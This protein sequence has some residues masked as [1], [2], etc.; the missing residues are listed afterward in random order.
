M[1]KGLAGFWMFSTF[2]RRFITMAT[3]GLGSCQLTTTYGQPCGKRAVIRCGPTL[4]NTARSI[5][6]V[7]VE[8]LSVAG[9]AA[10]LRAEF[11]QCGPLQLPGVPVP[12]ASSAASS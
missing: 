12:G 2:A 8:N 1:P 11:S 5:R 7:L 6:Q 3:S 9:L 4:L 10:G